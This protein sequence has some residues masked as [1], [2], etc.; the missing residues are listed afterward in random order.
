MRLLHIANSDKTLF[1]SQFLI[2]GVKLKLSEAL[3]LLINALLLDVG[4]ID[5]FRGWV[6]DFR[7]QCSLTDCHAILVDQLN[8]ETALGVAH[9]R[10]LLLDHVVDVVTIGCAEILVYC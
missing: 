9:V 8:Q 5:G 2:V 7:H 1:L 6:P 3:G 4:L 10:I